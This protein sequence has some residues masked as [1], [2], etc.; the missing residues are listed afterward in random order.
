GRCR[1]PRPRALRWRHRSRACRSQGWPASLAEDK[2]STTTLMLPALDDLLRGFSHYAKRREWES[3][4]DA[5]AVGAALR[6]A[7]K[8]AQ[9]N[10]PDE[11]AALF[12]ALAC[13]PRAFGRL[14]GDMLVLTSTSGATRSGSSTTAP[15]SASPSA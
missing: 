12:Y 10:E 11:P 13:R 5:R 9:G 7:A 6:E 3:A 8:L 15:T 4:C 2:D 14:H 1:W